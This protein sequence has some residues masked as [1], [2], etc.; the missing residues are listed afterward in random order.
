M[1]H[2]ACM[3]PATFHGTPNTTEEQI[4]ARASISALP[5]TR[6]ALGRNLYLARRWARLLVPSP[7]RPSSASATCSTANP[8]G[9]HSAN[10]GTHQGK[11][12]HRLEK[13]S[14]LPEQGSNLD[15]CNEGLP[16]SPSTG[17][18]T[19]PISRPFTHTEALLQLLRYGHHLP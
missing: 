10:C 6:L 19:H 4:R 3:L 18:L 8:T 2:C 7:P 13:T 15:V 12:D 17:T 1:H 16:T 9:D 11:L 14:A 5:N